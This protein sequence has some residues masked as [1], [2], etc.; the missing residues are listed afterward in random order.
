[1]AHDF[2]LPPT[3]AKDFWIYFGDASLVEK[4]DEGLVGGLDQH[5]LKWVAIEGDALQGTN[6]GVE[7]CSTGDC[8]RHILVRWSIQS[9]KNLTVA[10]TVDILLGE[11][12]SFMI[13][14]PVTCLLNKSRR[15]TVGIGF[16]VNKLR[17]NIVV[18]LNPVS[19][20]STFSS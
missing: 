2:K 11:D 12:T 20:C 19:L 3:Y 1:M 10:N 7:D 4:R 13:V 15:K 5:K 9:H 14:G 16:V 8:R 6:D 18:D 17:V